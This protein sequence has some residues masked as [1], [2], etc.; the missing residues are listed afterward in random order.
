MARGVLFGLSHDGRLYTID[1]A[2]GRAALVGN[3]AP[4]A[5]KGQRFGV[6]FNPVADRIRVGQPVD[7]R[8]AAFS[9][10]PQLL[11]NGEV[12]SVSADVLQDPQSQQ[13]YFLA[14]VAMTAEAMKAL[15]QHRLVPGLPAEVVFRT[16]ER[17]L[18]TYWLH[19]LTKRLAASMKE[20]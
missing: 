2:T 4:V 16:G 15:D 10:T 20:E 14:R 9:H 19:P 1:T 13:S 6:D 12:L 8:F 3:G 7:I 11:V 17:S 5:L 18:L